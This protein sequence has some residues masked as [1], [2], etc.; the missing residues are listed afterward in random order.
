MPP[1]RLFLPAANTEFTERTIHNTAS[2]PK[3]GEGQDD[4]TVLAA[5][6]DIAQTVVRDVPDEVGYPLDLA[7]VL[8]FFS[9]HIVFPESVVIKAETSPVICLV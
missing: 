9:F 3:H 7:L 2:S 1:P 4:I 8:H 5:H 6:I